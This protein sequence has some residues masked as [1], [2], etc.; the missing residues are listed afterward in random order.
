MKTVLITSGHAGC[1]TSTVAAGLGRALA[2][3]GRRVLLCEMSAGCRSLNYLLHTAEDRVFDVSDLLDGRC[4]PEDAAIPVGRHGFS[5]VQAASAIDWLPDP[6]AVQSLV[7][8]LDDRY[9]YLIFDCPAGVGALQR[10]L[11]PATDC[12]LLLTTLLP[13]SWQATAKAGEWWESAGVTC[14]RVIF[15]RVGSRLPRDAGF[16]DL[17]ELLDRIGARLIGII[18]ESDIPA[19]SSAIGNIAARLDGESRPLL[20]VFLK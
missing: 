8:A 12:L 19:E 17:D 16:R 6:T 2:G 11:A 13:L 20:P 14:Q 18:P 5:L 3:R 1:G 10:A 15:N 9:D 7:L 4:S